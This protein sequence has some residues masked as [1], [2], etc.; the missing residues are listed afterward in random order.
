MTLESTYRERMKQMYEAVKCRLDY[1]VALQNA[2][3]DFE[4][5][6]MIHW[7]TNEVNKA[8]TDKTRTRYITSMSQSTYE[9][10]SLTVKSLLSSNSVR[11]VDPSEV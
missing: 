2:R 1:Q 3:Q 10:T 5:T 7:I 4:R 8:I 11:K 6:N 9:E